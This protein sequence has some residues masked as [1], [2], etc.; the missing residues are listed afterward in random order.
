M[1]L[2]EGTLLEGGPDWE[3]TGF[4]SFCSG[5]KSLGRKGAYGEIFRQAWA[6]ELR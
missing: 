2:T 5:F 1:K 4:I 3:K 6:K